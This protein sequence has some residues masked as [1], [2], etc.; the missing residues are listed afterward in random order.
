MAE[1]VVEEKR[2]R[3]R[4]DPEATRVRRAVVHGT[5]RRSARRSKRRG[6]SSR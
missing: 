5:P 3:D 6:R 1:K 2:L 4:R